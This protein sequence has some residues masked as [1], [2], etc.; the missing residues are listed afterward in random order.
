MLGE[1][2]ELKIMQ[3]CVASK[4]SSIQSITLQERLAIETCFEN[5][6]ASIDF[7]CK[8][9]NPHCGLKNW[10]IT[11]EGKRSDAPFDLI[12]PFCGSVTSKNDRQQCGTQ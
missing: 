6:F 1:V 3:W 7:N 9:Y 5:I 4:E 11:V 8:N 10:F 12:L 2:V